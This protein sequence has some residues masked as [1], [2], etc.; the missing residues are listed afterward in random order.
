MTAQFLMGLIGFGG[1]VVAASGAAA[2]V[3]GL[4]IIPRY[5]GISRT[6][7]RI[8]WYEDCAMLGILLGNLTVLWQGEIP[9]GNVGLAVFGIFAGIFLGS[10]II[11]LGE[12]V[13]VFAILARR[14]KLHH[15]FPWVIA[16]IAAGKFLGSLLYF[17][18]GWY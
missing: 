17:S 2:L 10:W 11:A 4:G 6:P 5:A 12:V 7:E 13:D 1:G 9:L 18:K 16:A 8:L 3:I 14:L 15:S